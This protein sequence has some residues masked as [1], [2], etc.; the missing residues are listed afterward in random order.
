[1]PGSHD[2]SPVGGFGG[3]YALGGGLTRAAPPA[4]S[5]APRRSLSEVEG[6]LLR[7]RAPSFD[8]L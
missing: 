8:S 5:L 2:R 3:P 4:G 7:D 1:M 6:E